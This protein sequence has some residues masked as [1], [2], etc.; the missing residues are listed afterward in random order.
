LRFGAEIANANVKSI[1]LI[2][3]A[4]SF[5][6][7]IGPPTGTWVAPPFTRREMLPESGMRIWAH[8]PR[9]PYG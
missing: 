3:A 5:A 8:H 4:S 1:R 2:T 9:A 7:M 6:Q